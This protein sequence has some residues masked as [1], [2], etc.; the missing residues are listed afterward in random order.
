MIR[1]VTAAGIRRTLAAV[2]AVA[3]AAGLAAP[4]SRADGD[5]ASDSLLLQNV[6]FPY[7]TPSQA[8]GAALEQAADAV[9][10]RGDRVKVALIY[11][12][13]DLGA[14]P[15]LFGKPEEYAHYLGVELGLWYIGPLLVVMPSGFGVYDGGRS[16][17]AEEQVLR[18]VP[19][20][21]SSP[22]DLTRTATV[23]LQH[24][25]AA[26]ALKSPDI[27]APLVTAYPATATRGKTAV[28]HF[29]VFDDSGN[30]KASVRIYE[31]GVSIATLARPMAF[32]IGTR[33]VAVGWPVPKRLR[34]RQLRFCVVASDPSGNRSKPACAPFL[35]VS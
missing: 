11:S 9:Y 26:N 6:F 12:V 35:R 28:L 30:S 19:V 23:A 14:I 33:R 18:T 20:A 22:G 31:N 13:D 7:E 5:P 21:A 3:A 2:A 8:A 4:A 1:R 34:S 17:A 29:A 16:T 15:S 25:A 32:E 10:A 24:L 27:R